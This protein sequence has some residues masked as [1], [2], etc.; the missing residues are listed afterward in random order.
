MIYGLNLWLDMLALN[1]GDS[2]LFTATR[3]IVMALSFICLVE[4]A[5][6]GTKNVLGKGPGRWVTLLLFLLGCLGWTYGWIGLSVFFRYSLGLVGGLWSAVTILLSIRNSNNPIHRRYLLALGVMLAA[7]AIIIG[8]GAPR[9]SFFPAYF[10]NSDSFMQVFRFP[11]Q[12]LLGIIALFSA[13]IVWLLLRVDQPFVKRVYAIVFMGC[14]ILIL[15]GDWFFVQDTGL[16]TKRELTANL[17]STSQVLASSIDPKV[18]SELAKSTFVDDERNLILS[19]RFEAIVRSSP[20]YRRIYLLLIKDDRIFYA[21]DSMPKLSDDYT[22][23]G[24][25]FAAAPESLRKVFRGESRQEVTTSYR[26][27]V[28]WVSAF[29]SIRDEVT[30]Q[31]V[32]VLEIDRS[33]DIFQGAIAKERLERI[34]ITIFIL[35]LLTGFFVAYER[36]RKSIDEVTASEMALRESA[37]SYRNQFEN[38]TAVMLL[39]DPSDGEIIDANAAAV[40]FY[41]Y[42]R[43]QLLSLRITDINIMDQSQ[44]LMSMASITP[45]SA[46]QFEFRHRIADGSMRDVTVSS[47]KISFDG[48]AILHSI[49]HDVTERK[50]TQVALAES[51]EKHR[52]LIENS[53]DII[54]TLSKGGVFTFV[55]PAWTTLLGHSVYQVIGQPF[56]HFVDPDDLA[57][58]MVFLQ[59][60]LQKGQRQDG[61]EYRVQHVDGTWYWHTSSAVPIRDDEGTICGIEG[62][63]RDIT[64]RKEAEETLKQLSTRLSL[65]AR[66]GGVGV[67][68][69]DLVNQS[70]LW[71]DQMF[72]LYGI[73][74]KGAFGAYEDWKAGVHPEDRARGDAE[75]QMAISGER[76]FNT[77]FRVVW[78]D[79]SIHNIRALALVQRDNSGKPLRMVGTNWDIT[80]TKQ[81]EEEIR[82]QSA[83]I[84]SL[85]DSIPDIIFYKDVNGVYMGCN[86]PF[87]EFVGRSRDEIVGSTDYELFGK[88]IADSFR[89]FDRNMLALREPQHNDEL[90]TYPDGRQILIDTLK[91]PYWGPDDELLG[92]L[93]I[94][95]DITQRQLAEVMLYESE[96]NFRTFF[97]SITDMIFVGTPDGQMIYA[98]AAV[99]RTLGYST[100]ELYKLN[101]LDVHQKCDRQE[102]EKIFLAMFRKERE[103]CPLPLATKDGA[104][105]PVQTRVWFGQWNGE[106]CIFGISKNLTAEQE[107]QQRFE[108]LFRHNP[109]LMALSSL[110]ERQFVDVNDAFLNTLG[111]TVTDVIGKTADDLGLFAQPEQQF[112]CAEK[113]EAEGH[114]LDFELQV[115][116]KDGTII[117]GLFSGDVISSQGQQYFLTVMVDITASKLI[118]QKLLDANTQLELTTIRANEMASQALMA[119]E[120]KSEFLANMSHEIRTPMNGVIGM[121]SVLL[122]TDLTPEQRRFAHIV[123][124]SGESL[125][126]LLN[127]ILDFSKIEARKMLLELQDFNLRDLLD[128]TVVLL[129]IRADEKGLETVCIIDDSVPLDLH[130]D[131]GRLRQIVMN[132]GS[133][134][135]KFTE[136]GSVLIRVG[137]VDEYDDVVT[138]RISFTDTGIGIAK[139]QQDLL[140]SP[141]NQL[142]SSTTRKYGGTGLGLAISKQ[143]AELMGGVVGLTSDE[144]EGATFWF[145]AVFHKQYSKQIHSTET[146]DISGTKVV[147][148]DDNATNLLDLTGER[149]TATLESVNELITTYPSRQDFRILLAEDNATNQLVASKLIEKLGYRIDIVENGKEA[150]TALRDK[151]YDLV[152]MDCQMPELDGYEATRQIRSCRSG[153]LNPDIPIVAMTAYAM[154]G[155]RQK[156]IESGMNDY[157]S[158]PLQP[159]VLEEMMNRW[160]QCIIREPDT[161]IVVGSDMCDNDN[162]C[163]V[164]DKQDF[165]ARV[166][167]DDE[168]A[169]EVISG[170]VSD[171]PDQLTKLAS[172]LT[173]YNMR[174]VEH[175][176]HVIRGA[177]ANMSAIELTQTALAMEQAAKHGDNEIA[178]SL[179]PILQQG[180]TMLQESLVHSFR[181]DE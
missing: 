74:G 131:P 156:C 91:T 53:H 9:S 60:V 132:L 121:I 140:F 28:G 20:E 147:G 54:Y 107:A 3:I 89:E 169:R 138:I 36:N 178:S 163:L 100:E 133:N 43:E 13:G 180:F 93:G 11:H 158:K 120:A 119:N 94:S 170:F 86:P 22:L 134:A 125:L 177:S 144:G 141:F 98:N 21:A 110:P 143:L 164:F 16:M 109:T 90:I 56:Q 129:A 83:L 92:T 29:I 37:Q 40:N 66:A 159:V 173:A 154:P 59:A 139:E 44:I 10:L 123:Q 103:S 65:A 51:E 142:N 155:D 116:C 96:V 146:T 18:A 111:Y 6:T 101:V 153:V 104:V 23:I 75:I 30:G 126:T 181:E 38:N 128:D 161:H 5:R 130:G 118:Q 55:S 25:E 137:L 113:L 145:T 82:S 31:T 135:I 115:R 124:S 102:A 149:M 112:A 17:L 72:A 162:V 85:L 14:V 34:T 84:N 45:E 33:N 160:T 165:M 50:R 157:L 41:G 108:R 179:F 122:D 1:R 19:K 70:L 62:T 35:L 172:S 12:L 32:A 4:F 79:G 58:C 24:T 71:D 95:R 63:A 52:L 99:T 67:W 42:S 127:D 48:R 148:V 167:G 175:L 97:E 152:L 64:E 39:I 88:E 114:V 168:L 106:D 78:Q 61:V 2:A 105:V 76:E 73:V 8:L 151:S 87:A 80:A 174:E 176:A 166:M 69:Y 15:I 171:M 7:C 68:D 49:I 81:T 136:H 26:N 57:S 46:K 27:P 77:E 47:S 150:I 117:H